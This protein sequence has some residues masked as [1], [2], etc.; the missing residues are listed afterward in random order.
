MNRWTIGVIQS[1]QQHYLIALLGLS[2]S[3]CGGQV[4]SIGSGGGLNGEGEAC[5]ATGYCPAGLTCVSEI[6]VT[7]NE[8][9][10]ADSKSDVE[11]QDAGN[12][13]AKTNQGPVI[14]LVDPAEGSVFSDGEVITFVASF[15]DDRD[16]PD[17]LTAFW[18]S[19]IDGNL[20]ISLVNIDGSSSINAHDLSP[21]VHLI[22]V[23][24]TD[25][26]GAEGT[27]SLSI[28]INSAPTAPTVALAPLTPAT[29]DDLIASISSEPTDVNRASSELSYT[30]EWYVNGVLRENI[31]GPVVDSEYTKRGEL[32]ELR[33]AAFDGFVFG[34][35]GTASVTI[36]NTL[37]KCNDAEITPSSADSSTP[38]QCRCLDRIDPDEDPPVDTCVFYN[39][40]TELKTVS[41]EEGVCVLEA[42]ETWRGMSLSCHYFAGDDEGEGEVSVSGEAIVINTLPSQPEVALSPEVGGI[43]TLFT[44]GLSLVA[45]DLDNDPLTYTTNWYVNDYMNLGVSSLSVTPKDLYSSPNFDFA[46]RGDDIRCEVNADDG[47]DISET[48]ISQTISLSNSLPSAE[49][50]TLSPPMVYEG[51]EIQC[52]VEGEKD[53]DGDVITWNYAWTRNDIPIPGAIAATLTSEDFGRDDLIRCIA[54]PYDG[55]D[56]G[57]AIASDPL[58][59]QN[60]APSLAGVTLSP[61]SGPRSQ[62][63]TCAGVD[64]EDINPEDAPIITYAWFQST[65]SGTATLLEGEVGSTLSAEMLTPGDLLTCRGT[66]TDGTLEGEAQISES[67][68]ILNIPPEP[69]LPSISPNEGQVSETFW[70]NVDDL[71]D[72]EGDTLSFEYRWWVND[73]LREGFISAGL[74][75]LALDASGGDVLSCEARALD[76]WDTSAWSKSEGVSL[77]NTPPYGNAATI[78]PS[79]AYESDLLT[80]EV[81]GALDIDGDDIIWAVSWTVDGQVIEADENGQISGQYFDKGQELSC[82]TTPFDGEDYGA[83]LEAMP[84][85]ISNSPPMVSGVAVSATEGLRSESID[86]VF[87]TLEDDDPLDEPILSFEWFITQ[88]GVTEAIPNALSESLELGA[89][90]PTEQV[91]CVATP[92]DGVIKGT[93]VES[94]ATTVIN[95]TPSITSAL[96]SPSEANG[97]DMLS[98]EPQGFNDEDGDDPLMSYTWWIDGSLVEQASGPT[99]EGAFYEGQ[100]VLCRVTPGDG[101]GQGETVDSNTLTIANA[102]PKITSISLNPAEATPCTSFSCELGELFDPDPND[103]PL[104]HITWRVNDTL[105]PGE[106]SEEFTYEMLAPGDEVRCEARSSDGSIDEGGALVLGPLRSSEAVLITNSPP[107]LTGLTMSPDAPEAGATITC[108]PDSFVD[109]ECT[110]EPAYAFSW[111]IAGQMVPGATEDTF[112]TEDL[113]EGTSVTCKAKPFDGWLYG[114][115]VSATPVELRNP[116]PKAA[117]VQ[118]LAPDGPDGPL[119]CSVTS[120]A[121]DDDPLNFS[122]SWWVGSGPEQPG[123]YSFDPQG[124]NACER[125][126]CRLTVSDDEHSVGSDPGSYQIPIGPPCTDSD[127]CTDN[128]CGAMGGCLVT[129]NEA[130]CDDENECTINDSCVDGS[131]ISGQS[132]P[133]DDGVSCTLDGCQPGLGV[134]HTPVDALCQ[135]DALCVTSSCDPEQG[136]IDTLIAGCCG[137]G[138]KEGIE[139]CDDG[140]GEEGDGCSPGCVSEGPIGSVMIPEG[141]FWMGCNDE[142]LNAPGGCAEIAPDALPLHEVLLPSFFIDRHEVSVQAYKACVDSS[143][144]SEPQ[145]PGSEQT[146]WIEQCNWL[147]PERELHPVNFVSWEEAQNYCAWRGGRLPTEAEWEKAARGGCEHHG[148]SI[149]ACGQHSPGWPWGTWPTPWDNKMSEAC[150]YAHVSGECEAES[151]CCQSTTSEGA[152]NTLGASVYGVMDMSGNVSEWVHDFYAPT[153]YSASPLESPP[154]PATGVERSF[155]GGSFLSATPA[156]MSAFAR[157]PGEPSPAELGFRCA[158]EASTTP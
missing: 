29:G 93:S 35:E 5:S 21:G 14:T 117:S 3:A 33:I 124:L 105:I 30:W 71:S 4:E 143:A 92:W 148:E 40:G 56:L 66:P 77:T 147:H 24:A 126:F 85:T 59:I 1:I 90:L 22:T 118:V 104:V 62:V 81:S 119:V 155:R 149:S 98:C 138:I 32:W 53:I 116:A 114:D 47:F 103:T 45:Q 52:S 61:E 110:P 95:Q 97:L 76:Q 153:Y 102:L 127:P 65:P 10:R 42:T 63:F 84:L 20:G 83:Q 73:E 120:P 13:D 89:F 34:P 133:L 26:A 68:S 134:T 109:A 31:T 112:D 111:W 16:R 113:P 158:Y 106:E 19:N 12:G 86:C 100:T 44:C 139:Q 55:F 87:D 11:E 136:C 18:T 58:T 9:R 131:C 2:L 88:D 15:S 99:L 39:G 23:R 38:F 107:M 60:S 43:D 25:S 123:S 142:T 74:S 130:P 157:N 64:L 54:T 150:D 78:L 145:I 17:Q 48:G 67:V 69:P 50:V 70:C 125:I 28:T 141:S 75:A 37:P 137:N 80:C 154:G 94:N 41:A 36:L 140:N 6:C 57:M 72:S 152:M 151:S 121:T 51:Q 91:F 96:L 46:K 128:A 115:E 7:P 132:P 79:P 27:T 146:T 129:V 144:C 135:S 49:A 122:W 8:A 156:D 101:F 82:T 108:I